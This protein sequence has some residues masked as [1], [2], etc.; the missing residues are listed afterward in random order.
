MEKNPFSFQHLS[1]KYG[2]VQKKKAL[3]ITIDLVDA[4]IKLGFH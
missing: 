3:P 1:A 4:E 2:R